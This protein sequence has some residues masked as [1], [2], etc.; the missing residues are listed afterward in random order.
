ML[1]SQIS[2]G[3]GE[4]GEESGSELQQAD[5]ER[6]EK[7]EMATSVEREA[8]NY[9]KEVVS[10][11]FMI[12]VVVDSNVKSSNVDGDEEEMVLTNPTYT[13]VKC[14][15]TMQALMLMLMLSH[16]CVFC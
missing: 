16:S 3:T 15:L 9:Q 8:E 13:R 14:L 11:M 6:E 1:I 4:D 7:R 5:E 10:V 12:G 2:S